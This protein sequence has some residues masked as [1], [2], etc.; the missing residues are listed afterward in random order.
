MKSV[1]EVSRLTGVSV[2]AL[3]HYDAI[4][5]LTP[6]AVTEAGYRLYDEEN[7]RRLQ[8]ILLFREL[9]FPLRDIKAMLDSP[10]FD[11]HTALEQQIGLL[12]LERK[13][14]DRLI[15][16]A[17]NLQRKGANAA[18][19]Q[20][21]DRTEMEQYKQE[22][23]EKWGKTAAWQEFEQK[24]EAKMPEAGQRL[25]ELLAKFGALRAL[26]AEDKAVQNQV[27]ALQT[28]ISENFYTCTPEILSG[29]GQMYVSDERFRQSIDA[30]GGEGT[31]EFVSRAIKVYCQSL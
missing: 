25:M 23:R 17:R 13:R 12:E 14:L 19:F 22:A 5:L 24:D 2:R 20:A 7:L 3:H 30:A 26:P 28:H 6:A 31:A 10:E 16:H 21:F 27:S 15:D 29:L 18:D 8:S 11:T 4:G 1:S 9:E